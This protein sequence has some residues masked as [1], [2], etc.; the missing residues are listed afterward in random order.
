MVVHTE[1]SASVPSSNPMEVILPPHD[2]FVSEIS[3]FELFF[4]KGSMMTMMDQ[5]FFQKVYDEKDGSSVISGFGLGYL[6][7]F[8]ARVVASRLKSSSSLGSLF[9]P[10]HVLCFQV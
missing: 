8:S 9:F 4:K 6:L 10:L 5:V 2:H 1:A 7:S 3:P